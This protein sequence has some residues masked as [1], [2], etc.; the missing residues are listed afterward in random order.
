MSFLSAAKRPSMMAIAVGRERGNSRPMPKKNLDITPPHLLREMGPERV[1]RRLRLLREA[2]GLK[3]S[4]MADLLGIERTSW[5]RFEGGKRLLSQG[6]A[7][8]LVDRFSVTLDFL[9]LGRWASLPFEVAERIRA[10]EDCKKS[11][12]VAST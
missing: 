12:G 9:Y 7:V 1:G 5:S 8:L 6:V 4:E 10:V 11:S 3:S 2:E